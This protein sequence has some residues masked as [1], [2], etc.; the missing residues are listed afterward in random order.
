MRS[1]INFFALDNFLS[2]FLSLCYGN[3]YLII[4]LG[5]FTVSGIAWMWRNWERKN[6]D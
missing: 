1:D 2:G 3:G 6:A 4:S 5:C